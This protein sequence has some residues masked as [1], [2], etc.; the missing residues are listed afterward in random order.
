MISLECVL[1]AYVLLN[2]NVHNGGVGG[3]VCGID[4]CEGLFLI[5]H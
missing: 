5:I 1:Y 3:W 2:Y 4:L